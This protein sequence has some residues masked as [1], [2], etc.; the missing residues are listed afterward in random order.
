MSGVG[1][2]NGP[3]PQ[4]NMMDVL[5]ITPVP[6]PSTLAVLAAGAGAMLLVLRRRNSSVD[7]RN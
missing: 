1:S 2:V 5:D 3:Y 7:M 4:M 6:E